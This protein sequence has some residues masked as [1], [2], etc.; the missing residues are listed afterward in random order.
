MSGNLIWEE[1]FAIWFQFIGFAF[2]QALNNQLFKGLPQNV[3]IC[4]FCDTIDITKEFVNESG[5]KQMHD[6]MFHSTDINVNWHPLLHFLEI[7]C[8]IFVLGIQ[9]S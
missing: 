7:K 1:V 5:I 3:E 8:R 4:S 9:K 2:D 6:G